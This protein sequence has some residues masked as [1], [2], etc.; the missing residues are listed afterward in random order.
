MMATMMVHMTTPAPFLA[1][2]K[3]ASRPAVYPPIK[4]RQEQ[5]YKCARHGANAQ[6]LRRTRHGATDLRNFRSH[7]VTNGTNDGAD[8]TKEQDRE[9]GG[10]GET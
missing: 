6:L 8:N 3:R 7:L 10:H 9:K 4:V 5:S 2:S 1:P